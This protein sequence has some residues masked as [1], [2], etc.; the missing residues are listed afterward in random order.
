MAS[1]KRPGGLTALAV[2]NFILGG[3]S[4]LGALALA[5][6]LPLMQMAMEQAGD[7]MPPEQLAQIEA[8]NDIGGPLFI[9]LGVI[10]LVT[11]V[12]LIASGVGYL[13]LKK[14]LGRTL[15][16]AYGVLGVVS[17]IASALLMPVELGGGFNIMAIVG[18][19]Y[20]VLTLILLNTTFKEDFVY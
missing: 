13:K 17:S 18:L 6:F 2:I 5:A 20:P 9:L 10:S 12:L 15:G 3:L 8:M 4:L 1:D 7:Q 16:N 19:I 11:A 14:F